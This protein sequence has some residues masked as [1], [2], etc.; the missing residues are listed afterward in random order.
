MADA[1][2][3]MWIEKCGWKN[4][5]GKSADNKNCLS[6]GFIF[7]KFYPLGIYKCMNNEFEFLKFAKYTAD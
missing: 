7:H 6:C 2:R 5:D 3:K 1:D 4:V